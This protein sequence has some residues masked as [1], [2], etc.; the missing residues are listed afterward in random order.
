MLPILTAADGKPAQ[1]FN[2]GVE[3]LRRQWHGRS[4]QVGADPAGDRLPAMAGDAMLVE[5]VEP[6]GGERRVV[7]VVRIGDRLDLERRRRRRQAGGSWQRR[8]RGSQPNSAS[9]TSGCTAWR[10]SSPSRMNEA[11]GWRKKRG[12]KGKAFCGAAFSLRIDVMTRRCIRSSMLISLIDEP[13]KHSG[14][15]RTNAWAWAPPTGF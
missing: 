14:S 8:R 10:S 11:S 12:R 9:K 4:A 15:P 5:H 3:R 1:V 6:L 13:Q 7:A 2:D